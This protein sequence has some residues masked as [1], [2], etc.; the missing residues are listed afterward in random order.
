MFLSSGDMPIVFPE[1]TDLACLLVWPFSAPGTS[2]AS[3]WDRG[4]NRRMKR[5]VGEKDEKLNSSCLSKLVLTGGSP[6]GLEQ[7]ERQSS[8]T[9]VSGVGFWCAGSGPRVNRYCFWPFTNELN[10]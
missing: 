2:L 3:T 6:A 10:R 8:L 4:V 1:A 9:G 7:S 5:G